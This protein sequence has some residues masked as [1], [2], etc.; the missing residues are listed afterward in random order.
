MVKM[1]ARPCPVSLLDLHFV[2]LLL[3]PLLERVVLVVAGF[4][5][6]QH[7]KS[8][9]KTKSIHPCLIFI[10]P[11]GIIPVFFPLLGLRSSRSRRLLSSNVNIAHIVRSRLQQLSH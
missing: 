4:A 5:D 7:C 8:R 2:K 10:V 9:H 11:A 6:S 3:Q 1:E